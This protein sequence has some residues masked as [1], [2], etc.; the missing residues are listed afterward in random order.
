MARKA[1]PD[2]IFHIIRAAHDTSLTPAEFGQRVCEL[3]QAPMGLRLTA[4]S[5]V[6]CEVCD[7]TH[8]ARLPPMKRPA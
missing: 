7:A 6:A 3:A 5:Q 2:D 1:R 8:H 4:P